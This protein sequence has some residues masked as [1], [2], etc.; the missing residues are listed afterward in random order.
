MLR[1][2]TIYTSPTSVQ[3]L[4]SKHRDEKTE[5]RKNFGVGGKKAHLSAEAQERLACPP[6]PAT[7]SATYRIIKADPDETTFPF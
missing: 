7:R 1:T 3:L 2:P 4:A 5:K 6:H